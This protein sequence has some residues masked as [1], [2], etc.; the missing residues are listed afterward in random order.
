MAVTDA[1]PPNP[2][3]NAKPETRKANPRKAAALALAR[4]RDQRAP[5]EAALDGTP[6]FNTMAP[7]DRAFA[8][9]LTATALRRAG[10][11]DCAIARL[12]S[13]PLP[14]SAQ[15]VR[16]VLTLGIVQ[17]LYLD[18]PPHAAVATSVDM[19]EAR[20]LT[21]FK[22]LVNAVLRRVA[23]EGKALLDGLDPA[24]DNT[25]DWLW[26]SWS[27][28]YGEATARA[29]A[30]AHMA[31]A[32][33]D[34]CPR[35]AAD[36]ARLA[37]ELEGVLLP[38]GAIRRA[39]GGAIS[40]L[41]GY[42]DGAWWVQDA[43]AQIPA[44]LLGPVTGLRVLD[45]CAA[46]GGKTL[47]LAAA[48]AQVT[49]VDQSPARL[50]LVTANLLRTGLAAERITADGRSFTAEP[51][52]AV[53]LDAPCS[54]TGTIRRHPDI[55]RSRQP[56][57]IPGATRLQDQ[58]LDNAAKLTR[59]GGTLVYAVCSLEEAEGAARVAAFRTRHP[60]FTIDPIAAAELPGLEEAVTDAGHVRTLPSMLAEAGGID[61]FFA[62][63]LR[64]SGEAAT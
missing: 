14:D 24:R 7:R 38:T 64:R 51:F 3:P 55:A 22:G 56:G 10:E 15:A 53:L 4:I 27:A 63:R 52:D 43:A 33:L 40:E 57:D 37:Q 48:G 47:Q 29:I 21:K 49:A 30:E 28:S 41:P 32:P 12:M 46:P 13:R 34:L 50:D 19:C 6:G 58:L 25:P 61:G 23:R 11:I 45:L 59:P 1:P 44:R 39:A 16:D 2:K 60:D 5:L 18:T 54:A 36:A 31:E 8:R 17:L 26:Q 62:A 20:H 42:A 35:D 9:L